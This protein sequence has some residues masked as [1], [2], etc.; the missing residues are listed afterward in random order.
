MDIVIIMIGVAVLAIGIAIGIVLGM[1]LTAHA[2]IDP[3]CNPDGFTFNGK[4]YQIYECKYN[5]HPSRSKFDEY[6]RNSEFIKRG[7]WV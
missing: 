6:C 7:T 1:N 3:E 5:W 4:K 2:I